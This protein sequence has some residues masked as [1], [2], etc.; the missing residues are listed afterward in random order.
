MTYQRWKQ[1]LQRAERGQSL[2]EMSV[3]FVILAIIFMGL[4]DLGR[5]YFIYVALEDGAGEAALYL[6]INPQCQTAGV[7]CDDPNNAEW[8]ARNSGGGNVDWSSAN[9]TV[10]MPVVSVGESVSV[11]I[12]YSFPLLTPL[13][14]RIAGVNPLSLTVEASQIIVTEGDAI[15]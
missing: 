14:P 7:G 5:V 11:S 10:D 2:V 15:P 9:I 4:L 13:I 8:R 3:G 1:H 12:E 6:S